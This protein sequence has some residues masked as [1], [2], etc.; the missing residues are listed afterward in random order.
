MKQPATHT[1]ISHRRGCFKCLL[2][3]LLC[4][5]PCPQ[6]TSDVFLCPRPSD[7]SLHTLRCRCYEERLLVPEIFRSCTTGVTFW[8]HS[9]FPTSHTSD[10]SPKTSAGCGI[11]IGACACSWHEI[12]KP[13][14]GGIIAFF[15][16]N[17]I[18]QRRSVLTPPPPP[19]PTAAATIACHRTCPTPKP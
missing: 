11:S 5:R 18:R 12:Y 15:Y 8:S 17:K 7:R 9:H 10:L 13:G 2:V 6:P 3:S 14:R 1:S 19:L 4:P 16:R